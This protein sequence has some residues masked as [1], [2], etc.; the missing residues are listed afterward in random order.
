MRITVAVACLNQENKIKACLESV[1]E[2][3]HD[4]I[5]ILVVDDHSSDSSVEV[6]NG[7]I[8]SNPD[9]TF[10]LL[11]HDTNMGLSHGRNTCIREASGDAILFVD[12]DDIMVKNTLGL[13][14]KKMVETGADVVC[15]SFRTTDENGAALREYKY[16]ETHIDENFAFSTYIEKQLKD[17]IWVPVTIWNKLY[18]LDW[19]REHDICCDTRY[20]NCDDTLFSFKVA[21]HTKKL[22]VVSII[23]YNWV[24]IPNSLS[25]RSFSRS[26]LFDEMLKMKE[27]VFDVYAEFKKR[28]E[29]RDIPRGILYLLHFLILTNGT[30]KNILLSSL[31]AHDKKLYMKRIREKYR[32][33]HI[34]WHQVVGVYNKMSYLILISP[35][36]YPLFLW[37]YKHL[38]TIARCINSIK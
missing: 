10:R 21:L 33:K 24:Q 38:N 3:N 22:T 26:F 12:G 7:V 20:R 2:Q 1:I 15:G 31:S 27:T 4:D 28:H 36:P 9:A 35:F 23:S 19:L 30:Q 6:I 13:L 11:V 25:H 32:E 37:Y 17:K 5:E 34:H 16:S 8:A 18:R 29:G 14:G